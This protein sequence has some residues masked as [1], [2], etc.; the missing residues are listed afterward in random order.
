MEYCDESEFSAEDWA[1][2][3]GCSVSEVPTSNMPPIADAGSSQSVEEGTTVMLDGR[4]STDQDGSQLSYSWK[5]ISGPAVIL[6]NRDNRTPTFVAPAVGDQTML[7]FSLTVSDGE[8]SDTDEVG[9]TVND[10]S[11]PSISPIP[12]PHN[13]D[14]DNCDPSYPSVCIPPPPPDLDCGEI[15]SGL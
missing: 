4:E 5:Q 13:G 15:S 8:L 11:L 6:N 12:P 3:H 1:Q 2:G 10:A 7:V 14:D 9:V